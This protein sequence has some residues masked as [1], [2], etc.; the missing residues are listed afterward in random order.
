[1]SRTR[2]TAKS[3]AVKDS[4]DQLIEDLKR[5]IEDAQNLTEEA[6]NASGAAIQKKV[7]A[8]QKDLGKRMKAIGK[9]GGDVMDQV[10]KQSKNFEDIIGA[11]PWYSIGIAAL[12]GLL[13]DRLIFR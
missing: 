11:H 8:V 5:V 9:A 7:V 6:K 10:E 13:V 3:T 1:M 2:K 4:R 12:T